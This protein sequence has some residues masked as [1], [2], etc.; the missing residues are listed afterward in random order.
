MGNTYSRV[1]SIDVLTACTG[2]TIS[3][4]FQVFFID[5]NVVVMFYF[6][7][8]FYRGKGS[9]TTACRVKW[10]N[11]YQ[12]VYT[13]FCFQIAKCIFAFDKQSNALDPCF[14]PCQ[15]IQQVYAIAIFFSPVYIHTIQHICPVLRLGTACTRVNGDDGIVAV[16][17]AV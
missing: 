3:I 15:I 7:H 6:R 2:R 9:V 13:F 8:Y 16:I 17:F 4:H 14:F 11:T 12:T 1:G 10:R 5:L